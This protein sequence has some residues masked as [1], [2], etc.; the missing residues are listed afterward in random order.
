MTVARAGETVLDLTPYL[1]ERYQYLIRF[2]LAGRKGETILQSLRIRT[3]VQVAPASLTRLKKGVNH[4][5]FKVGDKHGRPT[6]PWLQVPNMGDREEMGRYWV[7]EPQDYDPERFT[8]RLKGEMELL[9]PAPPGRRIQ[10]LSLGGHFSTH[11]REAAVNTKN[12]IWY[13]RGDSNEWQLAYRAEV[14]TWHS[15][16][17]YSYDQEIQ[18]DE[19]VEQ[20]RVRYVGQPGVNAVR[21]N[22]HSLQPGETP[23]QGLIVTHGFNMEG[24]LHEERFVLDRPTEYTFE[25][26]QE[27][28]DV[29][30]RM[31]VPSDL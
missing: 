2:T 20:V 17:H 3:W 16:W 29:F 5:R 6:L 30:I 7:R 18:L 15:H 26:P 25:C 10:W 19:P 22:L 31:E 23:A 4:L 8:A 28:E 27:P 13:A 11:Q 1:R 9:F 21:V 12:E 14:P 24:R